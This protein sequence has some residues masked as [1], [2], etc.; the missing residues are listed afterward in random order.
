MYPEEDALGRR[1]YVGLVVSLTMHGQGA[2]FQSRDAGLG[3]PNFALEAQGGGLS[4]I[5]QTSRFEKR[6]LGDAWLGFSIFSAAA[7]G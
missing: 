3:V 2:G 4:S 7:M 1:V 6:T 5:G